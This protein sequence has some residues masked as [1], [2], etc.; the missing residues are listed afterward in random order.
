[1]TYYPRST[2]LRMI[3]SHRSQKTPHSITILHNISLVSSPPQKWLTLRKMI[4]GHLH[5]H[6]LWLCNCTWRSHVKFILSNM[7]LV[8][9]VCK[10][11]FQQWAWKCKRL[12]A[13]YA[14]TTTSQLS[15]L[16]ALYRLVELL[17]RGY[18][19]II[20]CFAI[21]LVFADHWTAAKKMHIVP[22]PPLRP[23]QNGYQ[24]WAGYETNTIWKWDTT[25]GPAVRLIGYILTWTHQRKRPRTVV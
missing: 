5:I 18:F 23:L 13:H 25:Y 7:G 10:M 3:E 20:L 4:W 19:N 1:M 17:A 21:W 11:L 8:L 15:E 16:Q 9:T 12:K 6:W 14:A 2:V 22:R 24:K